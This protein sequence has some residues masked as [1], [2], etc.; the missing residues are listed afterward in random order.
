MDEL[1]VALFDSDARAREGARL[2]HENHAEGSLSVYALAIVARAPNGA[3]LTAKEPVSPGKG[4]AAPA[5]SAAVGVLVSLLGGPMPAILRTV[6]S[7]LVSTVSEIYRAGLDARVLE[8]I[9]HDLQPGGAAII[10]EVE[11]ERPPM[12]DARIAALGGHAFRHYLE[13]PLAVARIERE[14]AALRDEVAKLRAQLCNGQD[15]ATLK[16]LSRKRAVELQQAKRRA[17]ALAAA[18]R[19]EGVAKTAV[20]RAQME[21]VDGGARG[22]IARRAATVRASFEA[23]ASSLDQVAERG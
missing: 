13:G 10:A 20:L 18:L 1:L 14:I 8:R 2:L 3:G 7:G 17:G 11:E 19:R 9:S 4:A 22:V 5:V 6:K 16:E 12:L 23:R 15:A 21:G